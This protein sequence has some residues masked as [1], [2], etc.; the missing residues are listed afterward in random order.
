MKTAA[1]LLKLLFTVLTLTT[2]ALLVT[3]IALAQ[4]STAYPVF[5]QPSSTATAPSVYCYTRVTLK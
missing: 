4:R 5:S 3:E 2:L 1:F